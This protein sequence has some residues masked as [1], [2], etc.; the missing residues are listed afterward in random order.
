[1]K[2]IVG[3]GNPGE[4]Y[5]NNRHNV[6]F[7][8]VDGLVIQLYSNAAIRPKWKLEKR[9][10]SSLITFN[11]SLILA[12]PQTFMNVSGAAVK[13]LVD[14]F[15]VKPEDL[16]IIH[17]D[18]DIPLGEYKTQKGKG[19]KLHYGIQSI[20]QALGIKR[21]LSP[22]DRDYWRVRV[23]VDNRDPNSRIPGEKYVLEDFTKE[24][25]VVLGKVVENVV[26]ELLG[27][28]K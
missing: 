13:K 12:K 2:L 19:P 11:P 23:G 20:N 8:V 15:K 6:G 14:W 16:Y 10:D 5:K 1:M 21:S 25:K 3:L 7:R 27:K 26:G 17:D 18:L 24:E 4:K 22:G 28:F 9:F